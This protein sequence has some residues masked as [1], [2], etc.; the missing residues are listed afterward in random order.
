MQKGSPAL[1]PKAL[2]KVS[3][4]SFCV[5]TIVFSDMLAQIHLLSLCL[6]RISILR[7][8]F[9]EQASHSSY[10]DAAVSIRII[11]ASTRRTVT[12]VAFQPTVAR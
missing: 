7:E 2:R 10:T 4:R 12:F 9:G 11:N 3:E 6:H 1:P 8:A 5:Y